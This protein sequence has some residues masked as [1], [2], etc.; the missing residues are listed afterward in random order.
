MIIECDYSCQECNGPD[1]SDCIECAGNHISSNGLCNCPFWS[2]DFG[3]NATCT[4]KHK[5]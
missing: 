1:N 4:S 3:I 2:E 5:N